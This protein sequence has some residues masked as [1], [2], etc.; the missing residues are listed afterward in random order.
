MDRREFMG[1]GTAALAALCLPVS[2]QAQPAAPALWPQ[3]VV[4]P[5]QASPFV[6]LSPIRS[7][8]APS[9]CQAEVWFVLD[10]EDQTVL[11]VTESTTWRAQAVRRGLNSARFWVG[12]VGVA[13]QSAGRYLE[14]PQA[15]VVGRIDDDPEQHRRALPRFGEKYPTAWPFWVRRFTRGLAEGT[16]TMI[17]YRYEG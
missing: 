10:D 13:S 17:R 7:D 11:V 12:D 3:N 5:L 1:Q 14:L 2:L 9:R 6:Y 4:A 16:R 15:D 8:G